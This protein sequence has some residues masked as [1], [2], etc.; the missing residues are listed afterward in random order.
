M[1]DS[2][3]NDGYELVLCTIS[4]LTAWSIHRYYKYAVLNCVVVS[5]VSM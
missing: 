2:V 5:T 4:M 1:C 3:E